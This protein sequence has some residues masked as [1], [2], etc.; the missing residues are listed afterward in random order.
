M[1]FDI[2][3]NNVYQI[4]QLAYNLFNRNKYIRY[5]CIQDQIGATLRYFSISNLLLSFYSTFIKY[6][7]S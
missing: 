7:E 5:I 1:T 4:V 3:N 6:I 2:E